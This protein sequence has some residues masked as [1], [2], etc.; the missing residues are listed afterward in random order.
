MKV[1]VASVTLLELLTVSSLAMSLGNFICI[2]SV[3][4]VLKKTLKDSVLN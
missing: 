2:Q 1:C 3:M 4:M